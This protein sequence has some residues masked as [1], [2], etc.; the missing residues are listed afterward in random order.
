MSQL[1]SSSVSILGCAT[2]LRISSFIVGSSLSSHTLRLV[3]VYVYMYSVQKSKVSSMPYPL[4]ILALG[5][6]RFQT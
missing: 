3:M 2:P 6:A 4:A 1:R 5:L